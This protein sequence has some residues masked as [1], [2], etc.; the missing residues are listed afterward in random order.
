M[1]LNSNGI[2]KLYT[3]KSKPDIKVGQKRLQ[4]KTEKLKDCK[5][6]GQ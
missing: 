1:Q 6:K 3:I 2:A 4:D 5:Q